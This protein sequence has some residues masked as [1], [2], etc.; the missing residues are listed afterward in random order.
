MDEARLRLATLADA[1]LLH[2]RDIGTRCD[3]FSHPGADSRKD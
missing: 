3:E 2:N 1:F